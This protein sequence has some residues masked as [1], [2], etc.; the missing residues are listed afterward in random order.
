MGHVYDHAGLAAVALLRIA[1][2]EAEGGDTLTD[3]MHNLITDLSRR[4]GPDAAAELAIILARR[5][6][7]L[8]D[9]VA[10]AVNVPLGTFLDAAE[11]DE[12]NR[13]RDG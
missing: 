1:S 5:C 11:L 4:K 2:E 12:L 10:D 3:R 13:V 9:S 8:L 6:F 7:T